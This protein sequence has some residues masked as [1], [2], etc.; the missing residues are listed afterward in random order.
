MHPKVLLLSRVAF[1]F[2]T[3]SE[4][5]SAAGL[6]IRPSCSV[7]GD[8]IALGA[9]R[10]LRDCK[11]NAKN[12]ISSSAVILRI[13]SSADINVVSVGS[14]DAA[15]LKLRADLEQIRSRAKRLIWILPIDI[16]A[17]SVVQA[18]ADSHGDQVVSFAPASDQVHPRSEFALAQSIVN[19][20][21]GRINY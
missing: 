17:R 5:A 3:F 7:V 19:V 16:Q 13:D 21:D 1:A 14:N 11:V 4:C 20:M 9:G 6:D 18:V 15:N 10:Y 2:L 8:S 12:G